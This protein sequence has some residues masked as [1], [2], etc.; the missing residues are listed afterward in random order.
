MDA[1]DLV[2]DLVSKLG[3]STVRIVATIGAGLVFFALFR[4]WSMR[5]RSTTKRASAQHQR[6]SPLA[7]PLLSARRW[8]PLVTF[9]GARAIERQ[10]LSD[11]LLWLEGRGKA[12]ERA[13]DALAQGDP[14]PAL[15][16]ASDVRHLRRGGAKCRR[17]TRHALV[18]RALAE[19]ARALAR[20]ANE[21]KLLATDPPAKAWAGV[22]AAS[23]GERALARRLL[24]EVVHAS[25]EEADKRLVGTAVLGLAALAESTGEQ[26]RAIALYVQ[27]ARLKRTHEELADAALASEAAGRLLAA[28]QDWRHALDVLAGG[29]ADARRTGDAAL[30]GALALALAP[31]AAA[32]REEAMAP[33]GALPEPADAS[34]LNAA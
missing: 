21:E 20:L 18:L 19:P 17:F 28:R 16:L 30:V 23:V 32:A 34:R 22:L 27:A 31:V 15:A 24:E 11:A 29:F 14:G 3:M 12:G 25:T 10:L 9:P 4:A 8:Q 2:A 5:R 13:R 33:A 1:W 7:E 6:M 26:G